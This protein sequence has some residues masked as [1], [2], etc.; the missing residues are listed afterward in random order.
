MINYESNQITSTEQV[1]EN[2]ISIFEDNQL[3]YY[4]K[5]S[6]QFSDT[7]ASPIDHF[8]QDI[9]DDKKPCGTMLALGI[10]VIEGTG[11]SQYAQFFDLIKTYDESLAYSKA[12]G[13]ITLKAN[14]EGHSITFLEGDPV[15]AMWIEY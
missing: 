2:D 15:E 8:S 6:A 1:E 13:T 10:V 3:K 12:L 14:E 5:D 9:A 11:Q 4:F 7:S